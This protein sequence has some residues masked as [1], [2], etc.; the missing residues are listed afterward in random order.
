MQFIVLRHASRLVS[1]P[2]PY[3]APYLPEWVGIKQQRTN[4]EGGVETGDLHR[5]SEDDSAH[6]NR[7]E[8]ATAHVTESNG[9][10]TEEHLENKENK[11]LVHVVDVKP[12]YRVHKPG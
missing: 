10:V 5:A 4:E 1:Y 3:V 2:V 12:A 11:R 8:D 7:H 6:L 9:A